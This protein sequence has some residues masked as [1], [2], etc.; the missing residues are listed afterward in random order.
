MTP[1]LFLALLLRLF[2]TPE[3]VPPRYETTAE[4]LATVHAEFLP[5]WRRSGDE[6]AAVQLTVIRFESGFLEGV[7]GGS[8]R[9]PSGEI[10]LMQI[11]PS[12]GL[13]KRYAPS[14]ESLAGTDLASTERCLRSGTASLVWS[15]NH[16]LKRRYYKNAIPALFSSYHLGGK[17]WA[18]PERFKRA[19]YMRGVVAMVREVKASEG[20]HD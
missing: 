18:S 15:L 19:R 12:N 8:I 2:P 9:G 13:W 14:F 4:A 16:C 11:H 7:H 10:C 5:R 6:P 17:C 20:R 3:P 1:T